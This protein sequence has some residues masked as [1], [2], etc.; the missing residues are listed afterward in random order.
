[1]KTSQI[2]QWIIILTA[3][4]SFIFHYTY[5]LVAGRIETE[6]T[7]DK[8][9]KVG[10]LNHT[11][12]SLNEELKSLLRKRNQTLVK[13]TGPNWKMPNTAP[14]HV[15]DTISHGQDVK[16]IPTPPKFQSDPQRAMSVYVDPS[17]RFKSAVLFTMDSITSYEVNSQSGGAAGTV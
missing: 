1:M 2:I 7:I 6:H 17:T 5:Q 4:F 15:P 11:L 9:K 12:V 13:S 8:T 14:S 10:A 16:P 3:I